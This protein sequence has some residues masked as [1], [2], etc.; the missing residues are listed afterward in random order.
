MNVNLVFIDIFEQI[1]DITMV[2][3]RSGFTSFKG[4]LSQ[5]HGFFG[6]ICHFWLIQPWVTGFR[7]ESGPLQRW[8]RFW[9]FQLLSLS[10]AHSTE[11]R[12]SQRVY[13]TSRRHQV[14]EFKMTSIEEGVEYWRSL[15]GPMQTSHQPSSDRSWLLHFFSDFSR[16]Y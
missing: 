6:T 7:S 5:F 1:Y 14:T 4:C 8:H 11:T 16:A 13:R 12:W 15:W 9:W 3:N 2:G 10:S